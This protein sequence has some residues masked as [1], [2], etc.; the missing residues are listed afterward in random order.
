MIFLYIVFFFLVK[1]YI[2][3]DLLERPG[4]YD[5]YIVHIICKENGGR[6]EVP[7]VSDDKKLFLF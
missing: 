3:G 7:K 5:I 4:F 6:T 2:R 1:L